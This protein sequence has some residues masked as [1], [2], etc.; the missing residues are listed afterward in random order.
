[1]KAIRI[2]AGALAAL[3]A[4]QAHASFNGMSS[5][6]F[7]V[8][9]SVQDGD[10][11]SHSSISYRDRSSGGVSAGGVPSLNAAG[12]VNYKLFPGYLQRLPTFTSTA[13]PTATRTATP[14]A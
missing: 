3:A 2:I 11:N 4:G 9:F 10:G 12:G 13:T 1:M 14:P 5:A 6:S 7:G 8:P